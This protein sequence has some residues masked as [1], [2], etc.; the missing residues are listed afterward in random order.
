MLAHKFYPENGARG[1]V[2][3]ERKEKTYSR[4]CLMRTTCCAMKAI[5]EGIDVVCLLKILVL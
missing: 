3:L 4:L 1:V 5:K 2:S